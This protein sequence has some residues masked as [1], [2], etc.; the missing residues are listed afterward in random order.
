MA[1]GCWLDI[2]KH[3]SQ[4]LTFIITNY[5][6]Q[7]QAQFNL[8]LNFKNSNEIGNIG[9]EKNFSFYLLR[10]SIWDPTNLSGKKDKLPG[11]KGLIHTHIWEFHRKG[12]KVQKANRSFYQSGEK[13]ILDFG[14]GFWEGD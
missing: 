1:H 14:S 7:K 9:E 10:S 2:R 11:E 4:S 3:H 12:V 13:G 5:C 8:L 6:C